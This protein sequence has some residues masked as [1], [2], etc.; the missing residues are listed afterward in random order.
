MSQVD[1]SMS[2]T[3][4]NVSETTRPILGLLKD[5]VVIITGASRGIGA[6][7]ARAFSA[8]GAIVVLGARTD[9]AIKSIA[10][11]IRSRG[12]EAL[13][14]ATD[15]TDAGSVERLVEKATGTYG[16][17]DGA[18]NNAGGGPARKPL[19]ELSADEFDLALNV[20]LRG[21]FLC[22]KY[23]IRA[24]LG[25][26]GGAIVNMASTAGLRGVPGIAGYV[27]SKHGVVGLTK[28]AALDYA[29]RNIRVN[30]VAPGSILTER[31]AGADEAVQQQIAGSAPIGRIGQPNEVAVT[32][33]WLLSDQS[34]YI[35]GATCVIDG[36]RLAAGA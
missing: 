11:E 31:L 7:S 20:N 22:M 35:T 30:T 17:L 19:A 23:E 21:V 6:E 28:T 15:V 29:R 33:A 14:V 25:G 27:A 12:G 8:A 34:A 10:E 13:A 32:V 18:F 4:P 24:M 1:R 26:R 16:R 2:G 36:G 5:K 9:D 3:G